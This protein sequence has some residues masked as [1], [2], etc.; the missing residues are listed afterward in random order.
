MSSDGGTHPEQNRLAERYEIVRQ[1]GKRAGRT[2][3]LAEDL[4]TQELVVIKLLTFSHDFAWDDLKLFEREAETL[5]NLSHPSIPRY[6]DYFELDDSN[7]KGFALVQSYVAGKTLEEYLRSGGT[8]N[9]L[10]LKNLAQD[11]LHILIYLHDRQPSIIHRDIKPS[12]ILI[13]ESG[14]IYLVDFGSVQTLAAREGGTITVVGTY[15]YMPPEQFG[16][17]AVPASDLYSLGATLIY[18]ATGLHP[19][20]FP[21]VDLKLQFEQ[22]CNLSEDFQA[23]L[24]WLTEPALDRR[25]T[26][27]EEA[28]EVL[29]NRRSLPTNLQNSTPKTKP[30][31][32][33]PAGS[34]IKLTKNSEVL[35]LYLPQRPWRPGILGWFFFSFLWN[36]VL[37]ILFDGM[38]RNFLLKLTSLFAVGMIGILPLVFSVL[39]DLGVW[40]IGLF[41]LCKLLFAIFGCNHLH[42]DSQKI[43]MSYKLFG[44]RFKMRS[45]PTKNAYKLQRSSRPDYLSPSE[46]E[47]VR[48]YNNRLY[49]WVGT[50]KIPICHEGNI[51]EPEVDWIAQELSNWLD[52]HTTYSY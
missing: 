28:L 33:K 11:L 22:A 38:S 21:Q 13:A 41:L 14:Q 36:S 23:W 6:L 51:T 26:T 4:E 10:E 39:F 15:G 19:A 27:A 17:R 5:K 31:Y 30:V 44:L 50:R 12:N 43:D 37:F 20:D 42:I 34:K 40:G 25:A 24:R 18:L 16:G 7:S 52:I 29:E 8:F 32:K 35:E 1:L 2:T 9:E 45:L 46:E 47:R 49:L 48:N 3:L